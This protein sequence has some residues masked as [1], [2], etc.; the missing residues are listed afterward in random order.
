LRAL[1]IWWIAKRLIHEIKTIFWKLSKMRKNTP[2]LGFNDYAEEAS[3]CYTSIFNN[4]KII[5]INY[6]PEPTIVAGAKLM[7]A[8]FQRKDQQFMASNHFSF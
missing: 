7:T 2:P 4:F 3:H 8:I 6:L 5:K 1:S